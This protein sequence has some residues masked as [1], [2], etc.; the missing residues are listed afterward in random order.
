[1]AKEELLWRYDGEGDEAGAYFSQQKIERAQRTYV[2]LEAA[3]RQVIGFA[4]HS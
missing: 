3:M 2:Q 1:M 4:G